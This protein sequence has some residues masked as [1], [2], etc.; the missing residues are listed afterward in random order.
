MK[1]NVAEAFSGETESVRS[2]E[3]LRALEEIYCSHGDT[4]HYMDKPKFFEE[5]EGSYVY[6][7]TGTPFLDLQMW[8]SAVNFGYR[9]ERLNEAA[10]R[11]L[12]RLPQVASQYLHREKVEL[13][14]MIAQDAERKF[15]HKGRVHFNVG[16]SQA[17]EDS[18]KLVRNYTGGKSLMFAFEGGY[19]GRTLGA[20]A[21]TSSYRYRRRYGHFGDRAQFVEFP[22][23]FRGPKGMSKEEYG[24]YCVQKFARL[25]ESEYNGVWDPKAG[26]SEYAAFYIEPIQGTGGYVIPP[27]NFFVELKKVLDDHGILLVVD[28]IQMG[29]YRTGKLWSIEHFGVSPDALIFGKAI[30]NG[31]NPLSGVW[32]REEM[33]NPEIFPPGS[34]HSTFASNPMGTAVALETMKMLEEQDFGAAIMEKGAHF[35]DGLKQLQKRHATVGEVDGLGLA[36]RM[37]ICKD[38]SYTPDKAT[39]DWM[40]DEGMKGDLQ[41]GGRTY[42]L[43]LDVGGY[44]KNVITFAPNLLITREEIDLALALLD[45]LLTRAARR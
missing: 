21:I 29:V 23:Y 27:M 45:Q 3:E 37:E 15:G 16:G 28:E 11:Q 5:C 22:Y 35:L 32:A 18:L 17:V 20:S 44:H 42:G 19:H 26:K 9:N 10:H 33:I 30:T 1:T 14:A 25:F 34:T 40:C 41:V 13:A 24:H 39:L 2:E 12:D 7:R 43:V 36:L 6:D 8:Y 4:V 38:D 31:L